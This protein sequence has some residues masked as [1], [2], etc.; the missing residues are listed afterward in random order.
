MY[1]YMEFEDLRD[2]IYIFAESKAAAIKM[3]ENPANWRDGRKHKVVYID[4][5]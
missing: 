5:D 4:A 1:Y 2:G 3:A